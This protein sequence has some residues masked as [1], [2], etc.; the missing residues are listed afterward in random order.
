MIAE[1][2]YPSEI[3][4]LAAESVAGIVL[5]RGGVTSHV[6]ILARSMGIPMVIAERPDLL[7]LPDGTLALLDADMGNIH[8][9]PGPITIRQF[10][11]QRRL[12]RAAPA[13]AADA[14]AETRTADGV[15]VRLSA[16]INLLAEL[17][18][19]IAL[20]AEGIGLYRTE[21]PFLIRPTFPSEAEQYPIYRKVF[22][23]M[24]GKDATARTLDVGGDKL[25]AH[26]DMGAGANPEPGLRAIRFSLAHPEILET[27]LRALLRAAAGAERPRILFPMISSVDEPRRLRAMV[28]ACMAAL[29]AEGLDFHPAPAIGIMAELPAVLPIIDDLAAE[30]DFM[31]IGTND[32][33]QHMLAADRSNEKAAPYYKPHHPSVLRAIAAIARAGAAAGIEVSVCGEMARDPDCLPFLVGAG[34][35]KLSVDPRFLPRMRRMIGSLNAAEA[36]DHAGALLAEPTLAGVEALLRRWRSAAAGPRAGSCV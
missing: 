33:I 14:P 4:K 7:D 8:V 1:D 11:D 22:D 18:T 36:A 21:F 28:K 2:L 13:L 35:R 3:L 31:A 26:A 29:E 10:E 9:R 25:P 20:K 32:L 17:E 15:R 5:A 34:I 27:Q 12:R 16:N 30:V 6:A 23:A 24:P 19:A